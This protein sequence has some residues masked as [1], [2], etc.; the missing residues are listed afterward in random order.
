M[1]RI[2]D[3]ARKTTDKLGDTV[4]EL[5]SARVELATLREQR[6]DADI[7]AQ[8]IQCLLDSNEHEIN[9][10]KDRLEDTLER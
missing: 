8:T 9:T 4:K 10:T 5:E 6:Q 7:R 2:I 1:K 3:E